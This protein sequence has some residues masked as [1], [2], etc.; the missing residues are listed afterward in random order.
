MKE[1]NRD[2]DTTFIFSTHDPRV[3][4]HAQ[5]IVRLAD[6]KVVGTEAGPRVTA[7]DTAA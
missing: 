4:A 3:M 7:A 1:L 2:D 6:G 5:R